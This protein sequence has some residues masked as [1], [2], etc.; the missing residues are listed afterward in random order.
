MNAKFDEL[1][2]SLEGDLF[3]DKA[4][5]ILYSTDASVYRELPLAV[6]RP[7]NGSD[8]KKLIRFAAA[9]KTSLIPR[10]AGTSLAGQ[11]V[12]SGIVVDV[13]KYMTGIIEVNKE[14][15]WVRVQPGV[16]LDELNRHLRRFGLFFGPETS[17]SNRCMI[18][19]MVGNNACGA[20][21]L[22]YGS[23]RDHTLEIKAITSDGTEVLF[24]PL[25][26]HEFSNKCELQTF[27]GS[28]YRNIRDMLSDSVNQKQIR[29][30]YPEKSNRR[31]N[32][33]Y[34]I[35]LLMETDPFTGNG[36]A[37]N[38]CKTLAG[39][40]GTLA[41]FVE[42][43]LHC[44]PL[45]PKEKAVVAIHLNELNEAFKANLVALKHNPFAVE[46]MDKT[47]LDCTSHNRKQRSNRFFI[48]GEPAALLIVE[49]A[50]ETK[51]EIE[52]VTAALIA[53]MKQNGFGYHFP[54]IWGTDIKKVWSLRKAGLGV[55]SNI[56]GDAK[57]VSVI[58]DTAVSPQFLPDYIKDFQEMIKRYNIQGV[59][60]A[61]I[62]TGEL[63][64]RPVLNL[65]KRGDVELF[66]TI[67]SEVA[68]LV[69]KYRGSL[70]GE[71]GVGRLRAEFIPF[72]IGDHNYNLLKQLKNTWDPNNIF[73][74]GKIVDAPP[75]TSQLRFEPDQKTRKFETYFRFDKTKGMLRAIEQCNGSGDC[76]KSHVI[77]GTMCPSFMAT[78]DEQHVTRG[79]ANMLREIL[80]RATTLN[81]FDN[82]ELYQTLDLCLSCKACKTECPSN[83]DIAKLK[84][85][86]LQ[87][88][89]ESNRIPLRTL[90]IANIHYLN[91]A[92]SL[93]PAVSN[94]MFGKMTRL[95][96]LIGFAEKRTIPRLS[97]VTLSTWFKKQAKP[98]SASRRVYLFNDEFTNYNDSDIGIKAIMLLT[99]LGYD[100]RI[101]RHTSSA[102][103]YLSKG[104]LKKARR[105]A[106]NNILMLK[107]IITHDE[108]LI[109]IEPSA[110]LA[111]RDE[112]P[113]LCDR[114]LHAEAEKLAK[115]VFMIDE[116]IA[117]EIDRGHI[118]HEQFTKEKRLVKFHGHCQQKALASTA[119]LKRVLSLPVNYKV[120]EI[121][122][123]CCG[124][125]G[126]FGYEAEHYDISMK[127][128]ELVLFPAVRSADDSAII[129][130][131]G[132]SCRHHITDGTGRKPVH[133][134]EVLWDALIK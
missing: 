85:E 65:K 53:D 133:P 43:K 1:K 15:H 87:H 129:T 94:Y 33:G 45:P 117:R 118:A 86:F 49:F 130:A 79:R 127:I 121:N 60:Y 54:I 111:F 89:Y 29:E 119:A 92:G 10:T 132:T 67:A 107:N 16:V 76:R 75:M 13:S 30:N 37:F 74:P 91:A 55:L 59:Y 2:E 123:G 126:S 125:A 112:Y 101:P 20:N 14:E 35:D 24:S 96:R 90:L 62:G 17:T 115:N 81:P 12:G 50:R 4:T 34:C 116:F 41:F 124:M 104:L 68:S 61:H 131:P 77:G 73:N 9:E 56:P 23:T 18:G 95:M 25:S 97:E 32:T 70:S 47:I 99:K 31:R 22:I 46:L 80:T 66:H 27:E 36:E 82:K 26:T 64:L 40:E 120:E 71:H 108:P 128:G 109:G 8:I 11:C 105:F 5:R 63:H 6:A 57:P 100:V 84:A 72:M 93:I 134:V 7:K 98:N 42:I 69:K 3:T 28:L 51:E 113:E 78:R 103:A 114:D 52:N 58:E 110:I 122:S 88:Y 44:D 21:S 83:V 48:E 38:F 106:N 19:G 39:S 102:R